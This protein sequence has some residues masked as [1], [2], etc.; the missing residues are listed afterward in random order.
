MLKHAIGKHLFL[1][2]NI[3]ICKKTHVL[4]RL[5]KTTENTKKRESCDLLVFCSVFFI[6]GICQKRDKG[7]KST[8]CRKIQR[9][10][11]SRSIFHVFYSVKYARSKTR[12]FFDIYS[13]SQCQ[14][15]KMGAGNCL[16]QFCKGLKNTC[17]LA[18]FW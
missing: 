16:R 14:R 10:M 12:V 15:P 17:F 9:F 3:K 5:M 13:N 6:P 4:T 2:E 8:I 7:E 11:S 18:Y 1:E